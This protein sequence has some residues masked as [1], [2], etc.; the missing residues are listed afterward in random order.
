MARDYDLVS[1]EEI[2]QRSSV[3]RGALYHHFPTKLDLFIAVFEASEQRAIE[4]IGGPGTGFSGAPSKRWSTGP[5]PT[6]SSA[7]PMRS[8][9]ASA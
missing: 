6:C 5:G 9:V 4:V 3:S 1:I 8:C 2:L 7:R